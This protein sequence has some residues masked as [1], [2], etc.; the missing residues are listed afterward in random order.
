[1]KFLCIYCLCI[2]T[3][4]L[5]QNASGSSKLYFIF[6]FNRK[7]RS[8]RRRRQTCRKRS[9]PCRRRKTSWSSC[10]LP[11]IPCASCP[12]TS[13]TSH[14][15]SS[16]S[17]IRSH[18]PCAPTWA[19]GLR[20]TKWWWSRSPRTG[21]KIWASF[22]AQSSSPFVWEAAA[23]VAGC[24]AQMETAWTLQWW[25]HLLRLP[26]QM[27]QTS[28]SPTP[29]W[30]SPKAPRPLLSPAPRPTGAAAAAA[31]SP[32]TPSTHRP[33]WP[34]ER[35]LVSARLRNKHCGWKQTQGST[36]RPRP[37]PP[38]GVFKDARAHW[39]VQTKLTMWAVSPLLEGDPQGLRCVFLLVLL[40]CKK[41]FFIRQSVCTD[42]EK[43][44]PFTISTPECQRLLGR[45]FWRK[46]CLHLAAVGWC[47]YSKRARS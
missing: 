21:T 10:L 37:H 14:P 43:H 26:H 28:Y 40:Q 38:S 29:T 16:S 3:V 32:Q 45:Q 24:T 15:G 41:N 18:S 13:A 23:S 20:W 5:R 8:W 12:S 33:S 17:V 36:A 9:R 2:S 42:S 39:K 4:Q 30:W 19:H 25:Q 11:T 6:S 7:L 27:L 47:D 1:M 22:S 44:H 46:T 31:I 35:G 34:S